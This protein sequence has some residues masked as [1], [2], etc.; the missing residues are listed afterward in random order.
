[1]AARPPANA[2]RVIRR[3]RSI[4]VR[5]TIPPI[6]RWQTDGRAIF[7]RT[8]YDGLRTDGNVSFIESRD[9]SVQPIFHLTVKGSF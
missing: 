5:R 8:V 9:L 3:T 4:A 1:M 7:Y 2:V 6:L